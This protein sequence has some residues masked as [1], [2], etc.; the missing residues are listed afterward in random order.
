MRAGFLFI[1]THGERPGLIRI[2]LSDRP[3]RL[4]EGVAATG[5]RV[6]YVARYNDA[7][8]ALMHVHDLLRR[9]LVDVDAGLYRATAAQA[10]AAAESLGLAHG[11]LFLDSAQGDEVRIWIE[12]R[13]EALEA[14]RRLRDRLLYLIGYAALL[15][16]V[17]QALILLSVL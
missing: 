3:P 8:A 4:P 15:V 10:I 9:A 16:G 13:A 11:R 7:D 6:R 14:R 17:A 12:T 1:E 2:A 5:P